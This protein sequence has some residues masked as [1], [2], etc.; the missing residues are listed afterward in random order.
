M[1]TTNLFKKV[2]FMAVATLVVCSVSAQEKGDMAAGVNLS[3]GLHSDYKNFGIGAKFQYNITDAIRIEPS[4]SYFL[5]KDYVS[6]WDINANV[7]YLFHAGNSF[8][9][10]PLAGITLLGAK[11]DVG[12]ALG[13]WEDVVE[14]YGVETSVSETKFGVNLG[15]GAQYWLTANF[16]LNLEI[17]YQ[18]VSDFDRP[19]ISLGG[20]VR[21]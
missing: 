4:A 17:K 3:Y 15:G 7:H 11:A 18:L 6:M 2:M 12:D 5:K 21:F 9:I 20:V 16:A 1:R 10:Y 14:E 13:E 8:V 19:V